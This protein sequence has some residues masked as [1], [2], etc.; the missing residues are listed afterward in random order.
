MSDMELVWLA[1]WL[2]GE[3]S[4][5]KGPPSSQNSPRISGCS[6]DRDIIQRVA[7]LFGTAPYSASRK[8]HPRWKK[9]WAVRVKGKRA[10]Y[11]MFKLKPYMGYR[12]QQQI[13]NAV[14]CYVR[15]GR[16]LNADQVDEIRGLLAKGAKQQDIADRFNV[17]ISSISKIN[18]NT[19]WK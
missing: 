8:G 17:S 6:T 18:T 9:V 1:G 7:S 10:V 14:S 2:E 4:F 12:R 19:H 13:D 3:G 11:L 16:K 15:K 5:M